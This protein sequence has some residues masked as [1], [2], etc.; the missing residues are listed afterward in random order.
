M[1]DRKINE[2]M[3]IT[4]GTGYFNCTRYPIGGKFCRV[5]QNAPEG[6]LVLNVKSIPM[7][8]GVNAKGITPDGREIA[9]DIQYTKENII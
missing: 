5:P 9:F 2:I 8:K 7:Y 6:L 4:P 3:H 1:E